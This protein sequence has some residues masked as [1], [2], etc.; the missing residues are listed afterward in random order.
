M[1]ASAITDVAPAPDRPRR[2]GSSARL[3]L[4][5]II[6]LGP[7]V[8][9]VTAQPASR[10]ALTA[11]LAERGSVDV[12]PYARALQLDRAVYDGRLRSDKGPGQP[13]LAVPAYG[14]ARIAGAESAARPRVRANL[15]AWWVTLWSGVVPFALLLVLMRRAARRHA[16][17]PV[18]TIAVLAAGVATILMPHAVNLYGHSL[19]A[20]LGFA[21]Y[22]AVRDPRADGRRCAVAGLLAGAA[23]AT[24]YHLAIVAVVVGVVV[25]ARCGR[26]RFVA[27]ALAGALPLGGLALYQWRAFG[28]PWR[29]PFAY[30]A[31]TI[32]GSTQGGYSLPRFGWFVDAIAGTRGLLVVCP[33]VLVAA[34]AAASRARAQPRDVDA[35][36]ALTVFAAYLV[37]VSGWSGTPLL[38]E[39]GPRYLI[40]AIPFLAAPLAARWSAWRRVCSVATAYGA[41]VMLA[42][43]TSFLL[44][45]RGD[46]AVRAYARR[47]VDGRF[48][49]TVWSITLGRS[50]ALLYGATTLVAVGWFVRSE[51]TRTGVRSG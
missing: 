44:V 8:A 14:L 17:D 5:T 36:V 31:G 37:L 35:V 46:F 49:P 21:A 11:A 27:F 43:T 2:L 15:T 22:E 38:E 50:G 51:R 32:D 13:L 40:P 3:V 19:S 20:L 18:A 48:L 29:M 12:G 45:L 7:I 30:Y 26:R 1:T 10:L 4:V 47:V 25:A 39:P 23:V 42:A 33:I 41:A 34:T 6:A 24:E 9:P 28:A 16:T